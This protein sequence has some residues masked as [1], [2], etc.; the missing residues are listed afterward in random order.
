M[1]L[2]VAEAYPSRFAS[3][4]S[5]TYLMCSMG[6]LSKMSSTLKPYFANRVSEILQL[7]GQLQELTNELAPVHHVRGEENPADVGTRGSAKLA[8]LG[9]GSVWQTSPAFLQEPYA[10]WP[11]T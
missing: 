4:S 2:V 5:Y 1:L 6:A 3:I 7:R 11:I 10:S 9:P 8:N